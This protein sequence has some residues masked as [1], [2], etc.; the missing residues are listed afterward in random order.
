MT[1][2]QQRT[3]FFLKELRYLF[4]RKLSIFVLDI[5][6]V[7]CPYADFALGAILFDSGIDFPKTILTSNARGFFL[8]FVVL[9]QL[10]A[11]NGNR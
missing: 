1:Y 2:L 7:E 9:K 6:L 10:V 3:R 4:L 5:F 8:N 11:H